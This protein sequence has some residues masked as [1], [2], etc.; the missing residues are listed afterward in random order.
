MSTKDQPLDD[1]I[2][3]AYMAAAMENIPRL[4]TIIELLAKRPKW[5]VDHPAGAAYLKLSD[6][7]HAKTVTV[8]KVEESAVNVDFDAEGRVI[9]L[10]IYHR[11][12]WPK[13]L[14]GG[15]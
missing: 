7:P 9:G 15:A 12:A 13:E 8:G 5:S 10:E 14:G 1:I 6:E 2:S 3:D 11:A 4:L